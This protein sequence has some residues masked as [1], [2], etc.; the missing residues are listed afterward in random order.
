MLWY[1]GSGVAGRQM[2]VNNIDSQCVLRW[3]EIN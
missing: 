2:T 3:V 1:F